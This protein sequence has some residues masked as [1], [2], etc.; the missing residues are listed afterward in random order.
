MAEL[1]E[2]PEIDVRTVMIAAGGIIAFL[3][4]FLAFL[5]FAFPGLIH[6]AVPAATQFP[7]PSV[8]TDERRQRILLERAQMERLRGRNG[9]T[10]IDRAM[11][12]V[13]AKGA[14][15]YQPVAD[16]AP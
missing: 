15:A 13:A 10:G 1:P 4:L 14:A 8:T 12:I 6:R 3:I 16:A 11:A 7:S 9:T 5:V 2:T